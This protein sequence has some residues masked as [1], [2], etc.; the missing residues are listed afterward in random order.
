MSFGLKVF[1]GAQ[2]LSCSDPVLCANWGWE[3][4]EAGLFSEESVADLAAGG[5]LNLVLVVCMDKHFKLELFVTAFRSNWRTLQYAPASLRAN[6]KIVR[7]AVHRDWHALALA[8]PDL[9]EDHA[10]ARLAVRGDGMALQVL[11]AKLQND[12]PLVLTAVQQ[13]WRALQFASIRLRGDRDVVLEAV[14][15]L[16]STIL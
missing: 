12:R 10:L 14:T 5:C 1:H 6:P 3:P 8:S 4:L 7:M 16:W 2:V 13:N 15:G 9:R 11:S